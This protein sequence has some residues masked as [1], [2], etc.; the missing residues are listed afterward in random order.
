MSIATEIE[1]LQTAK[2]NIKNAIEQK[3]VTVGDGTI[4]TYA[5]KINEILVGGGED[6]L[7]YCSEVHFEDFNLFGKEEVVLNLDNL[8]TMNQ[9]NFTNHIEPKPPSNTTLKHLTINCPNKIDSMRQAFARMYVPDNTLEHLTLNVNTSEVTTWNYAF[10]SLNV[11]KVIDG[12]PLNFTKTT[13]TNS[14]RGFALLEE[15][16]FVKNS[17]YKTISFAQCPKISNDTIQSIID[18]LADL[19][20]GTAQTLTL[21]ATVGGKL[22]DEQKASITAKNWTLVY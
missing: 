16:R 6:F 8:T 10:A 17:F 21:H 9:F 7:K 14:F 2:A 1:R 11:L 15:V 20:G 3:G 12:Q 19:T 13:D 22:T 18:G 4:D 5:E